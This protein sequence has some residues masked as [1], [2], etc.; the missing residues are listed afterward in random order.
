MKGEV[1]AGQV[2]ASAAKLRFILACRWNEIQSV[3]AMGPEKRGMY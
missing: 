1:G 2:K 3:G